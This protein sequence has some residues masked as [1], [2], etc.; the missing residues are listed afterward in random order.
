MGCAEIYINAQD[1]VPAAGKRQFSYSVMFCSNDFNN[2]N[3]H[4]FKTKKRR[5]TGCYSDRSAFIC[6]GPSPLP[7]SFKF[8]LSI[9]GY[10]MF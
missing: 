6:H 7:F 4:I 2:W 3:A 5:K 1:K 9:L 10:F 8:T